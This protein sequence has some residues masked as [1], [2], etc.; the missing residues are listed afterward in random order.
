MRAVAT[1]SLLAALLFGACSA[2]DTP[3]PK[4]DVEPK[5]VAPTNPHVG[6][7]AA[8]PDTPVQADPVADNPHAGSPGMNFMP[9]YEGDGTG[10]RVAEVGP[11]GAAEKCGLREGDV[12]T[13]FGGLAVRD[14]HDYMAALGTTKSGDKIKIEIKRGGETMTLDAQVGVSRR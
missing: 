4:P 7:G 11:G 5:V 14:V 6:V 12:I 1:A 2:P 8:A 13:R 3:A 9:D 10:L